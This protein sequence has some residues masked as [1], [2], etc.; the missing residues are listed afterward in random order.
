MHEL[1]I[2]LSIIDGVLEERERRGDVA[3]E[4]IYV[5]VGPLSGVDRDALDFAYTVAREGTPLE[6]SRLV[7]ESV[8]VVV[9]CAACQAERSP[10]SDN[11]LACADCGA[12]A[13]EIVHGRELEIRALEIAA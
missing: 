3:V 1:S 13:G 2:A 10:V 5:S 9:F 7:I 4:T 8:P 6:S 12:P 11:H